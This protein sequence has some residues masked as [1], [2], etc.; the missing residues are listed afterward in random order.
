MAWPSPQPV[1]LTIFTGSDTRLNLPVRPPNPADDNLPAFGPPEHAAP[2]PA[3]VTRTGRRERTFTWNTRTHQL[4]LCSVADDGG[5]RLAGS[6]VALDSRLVECYRIVAG[7][8]QSARVQ[9][10]W[11]IEMDQDAW[12]VRIVT[13]SAMTADAGHF[14]VTNSLDAYEGPAR[15]FARTWHKRIPRDGS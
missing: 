12:R 14:I 2:L 11:Q 15:V 4:E 13:H 8:P 3:E 5:L 1:T 6:G 9:S 10:D 7:Q